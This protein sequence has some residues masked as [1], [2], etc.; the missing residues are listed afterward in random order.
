MSL[1]RRIGRTLDAKYKEAELNQVMDKKCQQLRPN[2]R[3]RLLNLLRKFE[4]FF[5]GTLGTW[6]NALVDSELKDDAT[7]V[8]LRPYPVPTVHK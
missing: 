1:T 6:K 3:E 8:Y 5:D 4:D 7:P 2:E